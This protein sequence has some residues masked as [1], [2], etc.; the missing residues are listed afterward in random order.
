MGRGERDKVIGDATTYGRF[1]AI[2]GVPT[3]TRLRMAAAYLRAARLHAEAVALVQEQQQLEAVVARVAGTTV[4][5]HYDDLRESTG[6]VALDSALGNAAVE[7]ATPGGGLW[8]GGPVR[9]WP[10]SAWPL[11]AATA[12]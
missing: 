12:S 8:C 3:A 6:L 10:E 2:G 9:P 11:D 4:G 1:A 7:I 5:A